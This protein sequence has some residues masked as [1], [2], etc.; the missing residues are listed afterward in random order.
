VKNAM[1]AKDMQ[2]NKTPTI[3]MMSFTEQR[4]S[5]I[6][7]ISLFPSHSMPKNA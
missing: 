2:D 6:L 7:N 4:A 1:K 5:Y 3:C